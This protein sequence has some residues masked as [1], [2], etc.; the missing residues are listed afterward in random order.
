M[1]SHT[2]RTW[3]GSVISVQLFR[4]RRVQNVEAVPRPPA[5]PVRPTVNEI[6]RR[7]GNVVVQYVRN[8]VGVDCCDVGSDQH[9]M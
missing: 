2:F 4:S 7:L 5:R 1:I 6:L 9:S 3:I 8:A